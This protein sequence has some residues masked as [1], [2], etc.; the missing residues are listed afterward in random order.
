[1]G[2]ISILGTTGIVKPYSQGA[3]RASIY[4]ELKVAASNDVTR[5]VLATGNRSEEYAIR[6]YPDWPA[7]SFV[8][9]GDHAGYALRQLRRLGFTDVVVS[10]MIGKLSKLAQGRMQTHV[11]EGE[12]DLGFLAQIASELGAGEELAGRI[13]GANTAHHVQ[14]MLHEAA[15]FGLEPRLAELAAK[16]LWAAVDGELGVEVLLYDMKGTLLGEYVLE[17]RQ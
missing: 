1:M 4:V 15:I 8:Q 17:R 16:Q 6:R 3:Y 11:S 5:V 9:V 13:G 12:I 7:M 10:G 14:L 2:G